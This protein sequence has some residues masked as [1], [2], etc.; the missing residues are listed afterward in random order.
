MTEYLVKSIR[1]KLL[2]KNWSLIFLHNIIRLKAYRTDSTW[3]VQL[4][5][6]NLYNLI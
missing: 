4:Y 3:E 5:F 1:A 6:Y 2:R